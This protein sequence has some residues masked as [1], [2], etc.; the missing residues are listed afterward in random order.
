MNSHKIKSIYLFFILSFIGFSQ[1]DQ[2]ARA[3]MDQV[4]EVYASYDT[5]QMRF[6]YQL[7]NTA[8]AISQKE[9]GEILVAKD[10]YRLT[11][12]GIQ[13]IFDGT[14]VYTIDDLNE[15]VIIQEQ[16]ALDTPLNPLNIFDFHKEGY[17]LQWDIAQRVSGRDIRYIKLIPTETE[18][19]SKYLLLGI[20][21]SS[22]EL[23]KIIDLGINGTDTTF[24]I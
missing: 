8:E 15:E 22:K 21:T 2:R 20:D 5:M 18:S 24:V 7:D 19:E 1:G 17:L 3:L 10:K 11:I 9:E 6:S 14:F 16:T 12:L 4:S 23:Y 13:Q